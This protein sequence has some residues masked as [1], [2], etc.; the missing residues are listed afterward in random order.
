MNSEKSYAIVPMPEK[1]GITADI[2]EEV[3]AIFKYKHHAKAYG[4][5]LWPGAY[6]IREVKYLS[7]QQVLPK[8]E[9]VQVY[10]YRINGEIKISRTRYPGEDVNLL[11]AKEI[12]IHD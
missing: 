7:Y 11:A 3:L 5:N 8:V 9:R 1:F 10:I 2:P 12:I 6:K 4:D